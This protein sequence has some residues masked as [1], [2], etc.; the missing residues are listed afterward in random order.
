MGAAAVGLIKRIQRW[1][2]KRALRKTGFWCDRHWAMIDEI[3]ADYGAA[4]RN[5]AA[6]LLIIGKGYEPTRHACCN[7]TDQTVRGVLRLSHDAPD[8]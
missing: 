2:L 1:R 6:G 5:I 8:A 4:T 7:F 3:G